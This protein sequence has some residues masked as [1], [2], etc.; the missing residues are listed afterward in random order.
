MIR[1]NSSDIE[2]RR[3]Q[4]GRTRGTPPCKARTRGRMPVQTLVI[5]VAAIALGAGLWA[6]QRFFAGGAAT[7]APQLRG[8]LAYPTPR[9]LPPFELQQADGTPLDAAELAGRWT[10]VFFG[11]THC[12]D[13]CPTTLAQLAAAQERWS[14][15]PAE[16]RPQVLFVSVDPERDSPAKTGEYARFFGPEILAAT[17]GHEVLEPFARSLGML[18]MPAAL[19]GSGGQPAPGE[20]YTVD[21]SSKVAVLDPQVRLTALLKAPLDA[22]V[23]DADLRALMAA[24]R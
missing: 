12:P 8:A 20:P 5:L 7:D 2:P 18:Y 3:V 22:A 24:Q 15:L 1:M 17:A 16:D 6:G 13:V 23:V 4:S 14:D 11:F 19:D 9:E 21:H 10:L